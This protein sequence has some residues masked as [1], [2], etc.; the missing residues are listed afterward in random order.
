MTP[1]FTGSVI[2]CDGLSPAEIEEAF[3]L[4]GRFYAPVD[5]DRFEERIREGGWILRVLDDRGEIRGVTPMRRI[6]LTVLERRVRVL[7][8]DPTAVETGA[9]G[10]EVL[11]RTWADFLAALREGEP[12]VPLYA[13]IAANGFRAYLHLPRFFR[14]FHPRSGRP[15]PAFER[16]LI[17]GI[18]R[19]CFPGEYRD[20]VAVRTRPREWLRADLSRPTAVQW[21]DPHV[22]YFLDRNP[23][24]GRGD[25]LVCVG[26]F[27]PGNTK[28]LAWQAMAETDRAAVPVA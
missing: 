15:A 13:S 10:S 21:N 9:F 17:E 16:A 24:H 18:G 11:H 23:G 3:G 4:Y 6:E 8:C 19:L 12:G 26:E 7:H 28:G 14:E 22:R 20:G 27:S 2:S 25:A 1:T 5:R